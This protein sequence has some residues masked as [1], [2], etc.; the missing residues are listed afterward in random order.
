MEQKKNEYGKGL[1]IGTLMA[2]AIAGVMKWLDKH[3]E[4]KGAPTT[5]SH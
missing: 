1:L 4:K 5:D 2:A 3:F